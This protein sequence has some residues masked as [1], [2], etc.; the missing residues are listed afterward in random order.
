MSITNRMPTLA[1]F[2]LGAIFVIFGLNYFLHFLPMSP[3]AGE[4]GTYLGALMGGGLM[5]LAHAIELVCG[6]ALLA[7]R[8]VPLALTLL[9]PVIVTILAFH[10][11]Y[12]PM[13]LPMATLLVV[14]EGY[15]AW[16]YRRAFA[17]MLHAHVEP[18]P[19][20][21]AETPTHAGAHL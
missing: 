16:A 12:A 4:A 8:F 1:R 9:A 2:L 14:L 18:T 19:Y 10:I 11:R 17:P 21:H 6:I 15:L 5:A 3:P 7:N 20:L 13:G